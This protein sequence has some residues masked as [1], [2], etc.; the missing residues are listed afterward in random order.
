[1]SN[2]DDGSEAGSDS[3][4]KRGTERL[5]RDFGPLIEQALAD[6]KT[7]DILLNPDGKLWLKRLGEP[8]CVIGTMEPWQAM[9]A[10]LTL[11]GMLGKTI[12]PNEP[13][14][15]GELPFNN[16]RFAGQIP[17]IVSAPTFAIRK[18]AIQ[19]FPLIS[20]VERGQMTRE[21]YHAIK[22]GIVG[23]K[24]ILV[25]GGTGSGKT[26]LVNAIID[27][28]V[29]HDP[30]DRILLF[31]DTGE[32]QCKAVNCVPYHTSQHVAMT[33]LLR[34]SLRMLP[35]RIIVGE[36]RGAEALDLLD[37]WNT[38]HPGGAGTLHA[39]SAKLALQ[40]LHSLVTR[41]EYAPSIIE[42]LIAEAVD[43]IVHIGETIE[44][45]RVEGILEV[46]GWEDGK[47]ITRDI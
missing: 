16:E 18:R 25:I 47:Y 35:S 45:R 3:V 26:T 32:I 33:D 19:V 17:P 24:N 42:P 31:E 7:S 5:R 10:M 11:A 41:N 13:I 46:L 14:L 43:L 9:S 30:N 1:M 40:R 44:G 27:E 39:D 20:Y 34:V 12:G 22:R 8:Q 28:I 6:P 38:G 37:A 15:D 2:F 36:V 23:R 21:Q 29:N 4:R